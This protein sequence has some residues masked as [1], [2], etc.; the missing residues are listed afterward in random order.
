[1]NLSDSAPH[2]LMHLVRDNARTVPGD[3]AFREKVRGI[4]RNL[5]WAELERMVETCAAG[6]HGLGMRP[7][8]AVLILG[9][10]NVRLYAALLAT[11]YM[12]GYAMPAF[13]DAGSEELAHIVGDHDLCA[14][15]VSDQEQADKAIELR[16]RGLQTGVIVYDDDRGLKD[17]AEDRMQSWDKLLRDGAAALAEQPD[18]PEQW[19][20]ALGEDDPAVLVHSSGTTGKPKSILLSHRNV[21]SVGRACIEAD[22]LEPGCELVA[23]LP[24]GWIG[25]IQLSIVNAFLGRCTVNVP[26][27]QETVMHDV[28]EVAPSFYLAT[29]RSWEN[30]LTAIQVAMEDATPLKKRVYR[31]FVD[32]SVERER[33]LN[34][35]QSG[36]LGGGMIRWLGDRLVFG[37]IKDKYGLSRVTHAWTGGEAIGEET[38]LFY[39]AMGLRLRQ[40]YGQSELSAFATVQAAG[41]T[42][43]HTVG[44][45]IN[46]VEL[47]ISDSGE[48]LVRSPGVFAGYLNRPDATAE[49][50]RDGWLHT[51]DAG[52]IEDGELVIE[53]RFSE[54][55]STAGGQR[56]VP[57]AIENR[58]KFSPYIK[59]AAVFGAGRDE[60]VALVCIDFGAVGH[61]AQI[62]GV[63]YT[64][65]ADLAQ[66]PKVYD[67]IERAVRD[68]NASQP[69]GLKIRRFAC[70]YK[71]F[72]PDD[73]EITRTRK[74]RRTAVQ[75]MYEPV[76]EALHDA[77]PEVLTQA[78]VTYET[79]ATGSIER[80]LEL[81]EI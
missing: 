67:L 2:T 77:Q 81:R 26:E 13:P 48:V 27:S 64:S 33:R 59:D 20:A 38:F 40:L 62:N 79:G 32:R 71:Q 45:P 60:L 10:N 7:G 66:K 76:I 36:G 73:G 29:P 34:R 9:D 56:Y 68:L 78:R 15:I 72:D 8:R 63:S 11:G 70:L 75:E 35:G 1:M 46:G 53:G 44:R 41:A 52:R 42:K 43:I 24:M 14:V 5:T 69:D 22:V 65:Y 4:W 74:L 18:L 17:Y 61:W 49:A 12:R 6:L 28:R 54:M 25:D 3:I 39:R 80:R 23:Y 55:V 58:L 21:L 19:L 57:T 50:L 37:P 31:F 51:G 47:R 16:R 30:L